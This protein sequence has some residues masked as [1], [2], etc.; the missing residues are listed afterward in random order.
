MDKEVD[1][2]PMAAPLDAGDEGPDGL[3]LIDARNGFNELSRYAML[4]TVR[5]LWP[6][7]ARYAINCYRHLAQLVLRTP[8]E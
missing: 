2:T 6:K 8:A 5:H 4:W 7:G 3:T 1:A